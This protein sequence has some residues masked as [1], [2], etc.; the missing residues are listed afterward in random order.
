MI[1]L[2]HLIKIILIYSLIF[3]WSFPSYA[4]TVEE[5]S[6]PRQ[7]YGGWVTDMASI[8]S[9]ATEVEVNQ[10]IEKLES[11]SG[12]EIAVVTVPE[13][14]PEPSP[15]SFATKLFNYWGIGKAKEN[16]GIL[17][18]ISAQEHRVEIETGS[19]IELVI[20]NSQI[21]EIIDRDL[22]PLFEQEEF[23]LGVLLA[24]DDLIAEL[25]NKGKSHIVYDPSG[26]L[27]FIVILSLLIFSGL[28]L[29]MTGVQ[30]EKDK[31]RQTNSRDNSSNNLNQNNFVSGS[32]DSGS[33]VSSGS[34]FG[35]GFSDGGGAG[36]DF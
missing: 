34:D 8:L 7:A 9:D 23:D 27:V 19:G 25:D 29:A 26:G 13:T 22:K 14:S 18:L 20:P 11:R 17:F 2:G 15:K 35:G 32:F 4:L 33:N 10:T 30:T 28:I 21:T 31:D 36:G 12:V 24:V 1:K 6:N 16:N 3:F 5:V